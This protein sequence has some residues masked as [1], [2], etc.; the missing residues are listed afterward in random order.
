MCLFG[1]DFR[2]K[3]EHVCIGFGGFIQHANVL[4]K[5]YIFSVNGWFEFL[6]LTEENTI[7]WC[8]TLTN[9]KNVE[10]CFQHFHLKHSIRSTM[11]TT[12]ST[13]KPDRPISDSLLFHFLSQF[14]CCWCDTVQGRNLVFQLKFVWEKWHH[15]LWQIINVLKDFYRTI[16]P[17]VEYID[18][19]NPDFNSIRMLT[20]R[21]I[22][23]LYF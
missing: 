9:T 1:K 11:S 18:M 20:L 15:V 7:I 13:T 21:T 23:Q 17:T 6:T 10:N 19:K 5:Y 22:L 12:I 3:L 16:L 2:D 8:Y 4:L 14:D